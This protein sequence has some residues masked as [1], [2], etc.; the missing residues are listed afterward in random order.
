MRVRRRS[1]SALTLIELIVVIAIIAILSALLFPVFTS[2]KDASLASSGIQHLKQLGLASQAYASDYND[3]LPAA[4][5]EFARRQYPES[6]LPAVEIALRPYKA[7]P[8]LFRDP[9]DQ[10]T[11]AF[12]DCRGTFHKTFGSSYLY[13]YYDPNISQSKLAHRNS[14]CIVFCD[15]VNFNPDRFGVKAVLADTSAKYYPWDKRTLR[16]ECAQPEE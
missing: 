6:Q 12:A 7:T 13:F 2:A 8:E 1:D 16:L 10:C 9:E 11:P 4:L 5:P 15:M 14:S 3:V